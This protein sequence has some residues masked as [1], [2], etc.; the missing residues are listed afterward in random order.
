MTL[1]FTADEHHGHPN[2]IEYCNRP[3]KNEQR[4]TRELISRHNSVVTEN[5][6]VYHLGDF[7]FAGPD[8]ANYVRSILNKLNGTHILIL[9]NHDQIKPFNLVNAG[10]MSVHTSL[11]LTIS[12]YDIVMAHDPSIWTSIP[13]SKTIFL[14]GHIHELYK[15]IKDKRVVNVGVDVW[16]FYPV[17]LIRI[18]KKL[19]LERR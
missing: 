7:A 14:H 17:P 4:M 18:L 8:R 3:F 16:D 13:G 2:I 10:F 9:G 11:S 15:S 1:F 19:E 5:D 6:I 12:N